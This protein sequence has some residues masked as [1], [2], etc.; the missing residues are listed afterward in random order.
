MHKRS[1]ER[2]Y[3]ENSECSDWCLKK[4]VDHITQ[5]Y[6][7]YILHPTSIGIYIHSAIGTHFT[8]ERECGRVESVK[9]IIISVGAAMA[10]FVTKSG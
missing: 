4:T 5:S 8:L 7:Y 6:I 1:R 10:G 2:S 3:H 9:I